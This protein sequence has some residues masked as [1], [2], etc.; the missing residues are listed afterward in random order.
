MAVEYAKVVDL[1]VDA[2]K[3]LNVP[4]AEPPAPATAAERHADA[5]DLLRSLLNKLESH[6][7]NAHAAE[8]SA[9]ADNKKMG[10]RIYA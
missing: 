10:G 4:C 2:I 7:G 3:E 9:T 6:D 1:L 8:H 5:V